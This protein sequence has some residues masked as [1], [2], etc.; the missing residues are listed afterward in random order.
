MPQL[1]VRVVAG[2]LAHVADPPDVIAGAVGFGVRPL[3]R[4]GGELLADRD[5]LEHRTVA[6]A[7]AADVVNLSRTRG[8]PEAVEGGDQIGAVDV[9]ADLLAA[10][11]EDGVRPAGRRAA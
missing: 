11:A 10:V 3:H 6:E 8:A 5:G 9:V 1:P 4:P 7:A 2:E